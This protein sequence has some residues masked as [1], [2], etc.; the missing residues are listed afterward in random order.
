MVGFWDK[1]IYSIFSIPLAV[2]GGVI[3]CWLLSFYFQGIKSFFD[4]LL[5]VI[6]AMIFTTGL[7]FLYPTFVAKILTNMVNL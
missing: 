6:L 5:A 3:I 7:S 4:Y 1:V 2:L